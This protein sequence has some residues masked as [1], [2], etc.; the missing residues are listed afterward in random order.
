MDE[1]TAKTKAFLDERFR[2]CAA[3]GVYFAFQPIYGFDKGHSEYG[4][5]FR[6]I[7]TYQIMRALARLRFRSFLDAGGAEG[8]TTHLVRELFGV[9]VTHSELSEEACQRARD[10][11]HV[12][13]VPADIQRLPFKNG[14]FD[15]VTCSDVLEHTPD[16][17]NAVAELLR[18]AAKALVITV[19]HEPPELIDA[20]VKH[21]KPHG[22]INSFC[23][24][25]FDYLKPR[26]YRVR[27]RKMVSPLLRLAVA[28][29]EPLPR[30]C[31]PGMSS[32]AI[33]IRAYNACVPL[34]A[35]FRKLWGKKTAAAILRLD[36]AVCQMTSLYAGI[37]FVILKDE[38]AGLKSAAI[39]VS[40]ARILDMAVPYHYL[41]DRGCQ[42]E[43]STGEF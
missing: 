35:R 22:H 9:A 23:K 16:V 4:L 36:Q 11:F 3:D 25:S 38:Q 34:L 42:G 15:V 28:L 32:P 14:E 37:L 29:M 8:Y 6:Y 5:L 41:R 12:N 30:E 40:P 20:I 10:I 39:P 7:R 21:E 19:P 27:C 1:Y 31:R 24:T 26:G 18:V 2:L 33:A 13:S 17:E 43:N